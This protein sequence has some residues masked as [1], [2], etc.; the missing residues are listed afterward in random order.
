MLK[1]LDLAVD[2]EGTGI[3]E[4]VREAANAVVESDGVE[5]RLTGL[6]DRLLLASLLERG[7]RHL[8]VSQ[9]LPLQN[10][11]AFSVSRNMLVGQA[12]PLTVSISEGGNVQP[13]N[14][15]GVT[16][17]TTNL[18]PLPQRLWAGSCLA[19]WCSEG[20]LPQESSLEKG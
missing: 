12:N 10:L 14:V 1:T 9:L 17:A 6:F 2:L 18:L 7:S 5:P 11:R 8:H 16:Q 19:A 3:T 15:A 13:G 20:C 4:P